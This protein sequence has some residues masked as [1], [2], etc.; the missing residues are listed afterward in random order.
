[1]VKAS[2]SSVELDRLGKLD[3]QFEF[4]KKTRLNYE[5]LMK[6]SGWKIKS[7]DSNCYVI[8]TFI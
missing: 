6:D 2:R 5:L 3:R 8:D 4:G 7:A 1:M